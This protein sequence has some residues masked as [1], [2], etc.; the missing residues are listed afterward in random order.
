M[1]KRFHARRLLA[2]FLSLAL[3]FAIAGCGRAG[4]TVPAAEAPFEGLEVTL[5]DAGKADA[6]LL[7]TPNSAVLIDCG[8]K[9]FGRT[10]LDELAARGI[11]RIDVLILSPSKG[12]RAP[13]VG[14]A[15]IAPQPASGRRQSARISAKRRRT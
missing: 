15:S 7:T 2:V 6:I 12:S 11:E 4:K 1:R 3:G 13:G 10:I 14:T 8:K 9:D 5:F